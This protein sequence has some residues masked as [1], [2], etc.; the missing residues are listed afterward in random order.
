MTLSGVN[1]RPVAAGC[2]P[3]VYIPTLSA[4]PQYDD[5]GKYKQSRN[6]L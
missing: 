2:Q 4:Q 5:T 1:C 6:N 3:V